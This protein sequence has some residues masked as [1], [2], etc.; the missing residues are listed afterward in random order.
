MHYTCHLVALQTVNVDQ[1]VILC[2]ESLRLSSLV[3]SQL[4]HA[5]LHGLMQY[6]YKNYIRDEKL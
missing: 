2:M 1:Q 6:I 4:H 5:L 3:I